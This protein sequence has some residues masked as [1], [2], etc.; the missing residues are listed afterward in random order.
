MNDCTLVLVHGLA[1][2]RPAKAMFAGVADAL[3]ARGHRVV[4]TIVQ[5][6]GS[7]EELA[8]KLWR[9]LAKIDGPLVLL[10]HSM[11]GVQ[12]RTFLLDENRARRLRAI[13]TLGSPHAGTPLT[14]PMTPFQ[15]AYRDLTPR[16]RAAWST[17]YGAQ[18]IAI[19]IKHDI[20][21]LSAIAALRSPAPTLQLRVTQAFLE[22]TEGPNDG[23]I[24]AEAQR[25]GD[26]AFEVDLDHME[27]AALEPSGRGARSS[28]ET[29]VRLADCAVAAGGSGVARA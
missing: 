23:L 29:W 6:D 25:W 8:D 15:K 9:Q 14:Y 21:C 27:C 24:S 22:R 12:S 2:L 19:A 28:V 16:Q 10:C 1:I 13:A 17:A 7:L 4:R 5:G 3:T 20:R 26:V 18:E 11:G